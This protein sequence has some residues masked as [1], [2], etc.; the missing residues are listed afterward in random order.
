MKIAAVIAPSAT[1]F[2]L[3]VAAKLACDTLTETGE[4]L[5][6]FNLDTLGVGIYNGENANR[7]SDAMESIKA[8]DGVIFAFS[9]VLGAPSAMVLAFLEYFANPAYK[10]YLQGKP[11]L[12]LAISENG[13]ERPAAETVGNA[14][15][16]L[17]GFDVVRIGLNAGAAPVVQKD[18][19]ELIERQT[20]D[21]YRILRQNRKYI[22]SRMQ[23]DPV[24]NAQPPLSTHEEVPRRINTVTVGDLYKKHD[25][26]N[27]PGEKQQD[28]NR[29]SAMFA[30]KYASNNE[31][32]I[33][34][35][36]I[37]ITNPTKPG[38]SGERSV[39]QLTAAL[40]HHFNTQ[41]AKGLEVVI[42]LNITGMDGF[43]GHIAI[44]KQEC[45]FYEGEAD[46]NHIVVTADAKIWGDVLGKKLTAQKAF[47]M[48]QLK[49]RGNFV[50]L[51]KFDQLFNA[52]S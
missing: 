46:K 49:V 52:V 35:Q 13:G 37:P 41:H 34:Q 10:V 11:C 4:T 12:L 45:F 17:G 1:D 51:T 43:S 31:A 27:M 9:V 36:P 6:I 15:M 23:A 48:G 20:E 26:E 21:F 40:P 8:A 28:I 38:F 18:V 3:N 19:I 16:Q 22:I 44:A 39:K 25:L 32:L 14:I 33:E 2:G 24:L 7:V 50:L 29:I 42:Q 5:Q 30:K 47:M